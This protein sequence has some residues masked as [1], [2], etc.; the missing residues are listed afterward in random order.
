MIERMIGVRTDHDETQRELAAAIGYHQVQIA[1]Y[2]TGVNAP[3]IDYL[4]KFCRHYHVS[5][6]YILGLPRNGEWPR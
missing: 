6:D 3:P 1:R 2:E 4:V 5:A